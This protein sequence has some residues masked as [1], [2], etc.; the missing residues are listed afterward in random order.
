M[1]KKFVIVALLGTLVI[2]SVTALY[3]TTG[4]Q[5]D[6]AAQLEEFRNSARDLGLPASLSEVYP[7][8]SVIETNNSAPLIVIA[9][10]LIA[11][12]EEMAIETLLA[13][14]EK[15]SCE[16]DWEK[17][18]ETGFVESLKVP[19]AVALLLT[20]ARDDISSDDS[21]E[22][23]KKILA[24]EKIA[25]HLVSIPTPEALAESARAERELLLSLG[26]VMLEFHD[27]KELLVL[28][29]EVGK[30]TRPIGVL[31]RC[32]RSMVVE[33][34]AAAS[35][36]DGIVEKI[37]QGFPADP[38]G[39]G[40]VEARHLEGWLELYGGLEEIDD[41]PAAA[42]YL[43]TVTEE[44]AKDERP[45]SYT[46]R[47]TDKSFIEGA[48]LAAE[49]VAIRRI[50]FVAA[51]T[52]DYGRVHTQFTAQIPIRGGL[53]TDPFRGEKLEYSTLGTGFKIYSWGYDRLDSGGTS[54]PG[55]TFEN[56]DIGFKYTPSSQR[57]D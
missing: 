2:G 6:T 22:A 50:L 12:D 16:F 45:S 4:E 57:D 39:S 34:S 48:K 42:E 31:N 3:A 9:S 49:N 7:N 24:A 30:R 41:W 17:A 10:G 21:S 19:E 54:K 27:N 13:A 51:A 52:F 28:V 47:T 44:W 8:E 53:A 11:D 38:W 26:D 25:S 46:L 1:K 20:S 18:Q 32:L 43:E 40:A 14:G 29:Q 56:G 37:Q 23:F 35:R 5:R 36:F 33:G 55:L 15:S